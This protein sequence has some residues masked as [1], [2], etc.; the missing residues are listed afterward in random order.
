[1]TENGNN[2]VVEPVAPEGATEITIQVKYKNY[3]EVFDVSQ[4]QVVV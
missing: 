4:I 1:M 2:F 3:P